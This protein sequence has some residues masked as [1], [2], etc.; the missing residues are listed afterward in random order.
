MNAFDSIVNKKPR[1]N[2]GAPASNL[3]LAYFF[4]YLYIMY[5]YGLAPTYL[6]QFFRKCLAVTKVFHKFVA[7]KGYRYQLS[8]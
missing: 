5:R 4:S 6:R 8:S 2:A 1:E 3:A 7:R